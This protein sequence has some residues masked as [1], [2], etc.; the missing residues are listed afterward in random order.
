MTHLVKVVPLALVAGL[1]A[2][3]ISRL[4]FLPAPGYIVPGVIGLAL[5]GVAGL[6]VYFVGA[7]AMRMPEVAGVMRRLGR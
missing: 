4:P 6:G 1:V 7:V 3:L 2:W 5:A